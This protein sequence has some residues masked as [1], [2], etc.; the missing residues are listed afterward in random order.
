MMIT[1]IT[2]GVAFPIRYSQ[3]VNSSGATIASIQ[4]AIEYFL[5][6]VLFVLALML[7]VRRPNEA[8]AVMI[9]I[10]LP[11][12]IPN[13]AGLSHLATKL[14]PIFHLTS[15]IIIITTTSLVFVC[16]ISLPDGY[17]RP[18]RLLWLIPPFLVYEVTRY[19]LFF[20]YAPPELE[21]LRPAVLTI[22][23]LFILI[24]VIAM[25]YRYRFHAT[26][27]QRQQFKWLL[28]GLIIVIGLMGIIQTLRLVSV[29]FGGETINLPLIA[30]IVL[31]TSGIILSM[32]LV[33]AITRYGLWDVDLTINRSV[34]VTGVTIILVVVFVG[35]FILSQTILHHILGENR[36]DIAIGVAGL[37]MGG[38][39]NPVRHRVRTFVDR[40]LY[41]FRFDLNQ[42]E[43]HHE[44]A[45]VSN[46]G[47]FT[48]KTLGGY[49]LLDVIGRGGMGEVYKGI[50]DNKYA[51]VKVMHIAHSQ[52]L[53]SR[54]RFRREG[55]ISLDHP[56]IVKTLASGEEDNIYYMIIEYVDGITLKEFM[57]ENHLAP[58][59]VV[60]P[61]LHDLAGAIDYA[62]FKGYVHR[63]IKPSNIMLQ[64]TDT[65][66]PPKI[67]LMD[68]GVAKSVDD[69]GS[70]TG[71][72]AVG[73]IDYMAPEQ[74]KDSTNVDHRAD[75]YALGVVVY[76]LLS[77]KLPFEGNVAQ[78]LFAHVN[79]PPPDVRKINPDLSLAVA[80]A[81]QR[82]LQKDPDDRFQSARE[83]IQALYS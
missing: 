45:D 65:N 24:A 27:A 80:I 71:S 28:W 4:I 17:P 11:V 74:I 1:F 42:L 62:H 47:A 72:A 61:Y 49:Q 36:R 73:T 78:V 67:V 79:Q 66:R 46:P 6:V 60:Y 56:H 37:V 2:Y 44:P 10:S 13:F 54:S 52:S 81:L 75:L 70:L 5:V 14:H 25:I 18:R 16:L 34:V 50:A 57:S 7:V 58:L 48:G 8:I 76:E 21:R 35:M 26:P 33:F 31:T 40:R 3:L 20:V 69:T 39:F 43:R 19:I 23:A 12:G 32:A 38:M 68:F 59:E 77:G 9:G 82:I 64:Q 83:F 30:N 55:K 53:S 29:R 15:G 41:G 51:A 22:N 63:D